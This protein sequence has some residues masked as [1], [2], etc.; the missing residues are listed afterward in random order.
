MARRGRAIEG[1]ATHHHDACLGPWALDNTNARQARLETLAQKPRE[2]STHEPVLDMNLDHIVR[3]ALI[4]ENWRLESDAAKQ[5]I[6]A[7]F[8]EALAALA[9]IVEGI[10]PASILG[11]RRGS[12]SRGLIGTSTGPGIANV[13][14]KGDKSLASSIKILRTV[15][16]TLNVTSQ[17]APVEESYDA[18]LDDLVSRLK[19]TTE[20]APFNSAFAGFLARH[21]HRGPND[22]ELSSRTLGAQPRAC[23]G[24]H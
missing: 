8:T 22:W 7:P 20:A 10:V 6:S 3:I 18:G 23:A 21:G 14:R 11:K 9:Q 24:C 17:P 12:C 1:K 2:Q 5:G 4:G 13:P 16:K 15:L 19:N